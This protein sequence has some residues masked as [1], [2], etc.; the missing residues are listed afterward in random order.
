MFF[1]HTLQGV[2]GPEMA[3]TKLFASYKS[4]AN[5]KGYGFGVHCMKNIPMESQIQVI[6]S[7]VLKLHCLGKVY[8]SLSKYSTAGHCPGGSKSAS[9]C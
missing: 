2:D 5:M 1:E 7:L 8:P 3:V 4:N 9:F 6:F